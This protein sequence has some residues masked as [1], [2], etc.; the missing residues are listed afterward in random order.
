M[1]RR[2]LVRIVPTK[3]LRLLEIR[4]NVQMATKRKRARSIKSKKNYPLL[5]LRGIKRRIGALDA[6]N[7][8]TL[9]A[10]VPR[11]IKELHKW[12]MFYPTITMMCQDLLNFYILERE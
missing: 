4:I 7:M 2:H 10:T 6:G 12:H 3:I 9:T 1:E 5:I 11:R 8:G